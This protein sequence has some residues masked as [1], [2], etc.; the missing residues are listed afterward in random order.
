MPPRK[1][2]VSTARRDL[3][4]AAVALIPL[5]LLARFL[6]NGVG[7]GS[8]MEPLEAVTAA[9]TFIFGW[10]SW[11]RWREH[12][13]EAA[14]HKQTEADLRIKE[15]RLS[16]LLDA[17]RDRFWESDEHHR[18]IWRSAPSG[19]AAPDDDFLNKT[20]W[21]AIGA[22]PATDPHWAAHHADLENRRPIRDFR[23][24]KVKNGRI[25]HRSLNGRPFFDEQ[26][27]FKGYR[28][29]TTNITR[30]IEARLDAAEIQAQFL[31]AIENI[32]DGYALWSGDDTLIACNERFARLHGAP[33]ARDSLG[34]PFVSFVRG[35]ASG[36][37]AGSESWVHD[38]LAWHRGSAA[39][40]HVRRG[41]AWIEMREHHL[42][43]GRV[44]TVTRD[45]TEQKELERQLQQAQK[46]KAVGQLTGG[47]AHDFN[48]LLQV[49]LGNIEL[50]IDQVP[51]G[52]P[53]AAQA[54]IVK[55]ASERGADLILRL[56]AF[57]RQQ[58]LQPETFDLNE[59]AAEMSEIAR[60]TLGEDIVIR[61]QLAPALSPVYLDRVQAE[62]AFLN[63]AINA[64]DAMPDGGT[65]LVETA[66]V[67]REDHAASDQ[68]ELTAGRYAVLSI[69][70]TGRGMP[71]EVLARVF[72]P[73]F[74]TKDVGKG[75]GLGLS[76]TYGF[77]KQSGGD[78]KIHSEPGFG[79]LVKLYLPTAQKQRWKSHGQTL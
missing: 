14:L 40:F 4:W 2:P 59:L 45:I 74:T 16:E 9:L 21:E 54:A 41:G 71:P 68:L 70:D 72:E 52:S 65:L 36:I 6:D 24:T 48:N 44:L 56:L 76:M 22:D 17:A 19:R 73:F 53:Q 69:A 79:T 28:G 11:R 64:R 33:S 29:T 77:I 51:R 25:V 49:I 42:P 20:R 8:W 58:S 30:E 38:C 61:T 26:G 31:S 10:F 67:V 62:A 43:D 78:V 12:A 13:R 5:A 50:I 66:D 63:L 55:A 57:S 37:D 15:R 1:P 3:V 47:I 27:R 60:R 35:F 23:Y 46:M 18:V 7:V 32:A 34:I 39:P 75:S